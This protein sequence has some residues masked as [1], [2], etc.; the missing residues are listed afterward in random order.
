[1]LRMQ[2]SI[3]HTL[4]Q[5]IYRIAERGPDLDQ[6]AREALASGCRSYSRMYR[7]HAAFEDTKMWPALRETVPTSTYA[8]IVDAFD[9]AA[10][11]QLGEDGFAGAVE[12]MAEIEQE[13]GI[14][15]LSDFTP[16]ELP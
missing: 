15:G 14:R 12:R 6:D 3:G 5:R 11:E 9:Q 16:A 4:A 13:L 8:D 2:H 10:A 7:A 1:M